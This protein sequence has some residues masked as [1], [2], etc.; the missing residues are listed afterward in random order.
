MFEH[1]DGDS[2]LELTEW[3]E[4]P[5]CPRCGQRRQARC[6]TCGFAADNFPLADYQE[7]GADLFPSRGRSDSR[8]LDSGPDADVL[9]LCG[10]CEEAFRPGF[11]DRCAACGH[12]F[13]GGVRIRREDD[14]LLSDRVVWA[15]IAL[16]AFVFALAVYF[17]VIF[18]A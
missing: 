5:C 6:S 7:F 4:W 12:D 18:R 15:S 2:P 17:W 14:D 13:G 3:T 8:L 10:V 1:V 16:T 9:L 11:Y